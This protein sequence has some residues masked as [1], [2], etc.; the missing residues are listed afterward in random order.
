M[1]LNTYTA[2]G[3]AIATVM[4]VSYSDISAVV[5]DIITVGETRLLREVRTRDMETAL[6][7]LTIA[8]GV[9]TVPSAYLE[10]KHAYID[11]SPTQWL[12]RKPASW[13]YQYYPNR[14]SDG[15]PS[16]IAR[17]G[18]NFIFGPYPDSGYTVKGVYYKSPGS[19]SASAHTF[20]TNNPDLYLFACL[21]E[22]SIFIS[23]QSKIPVWEAKY[24]KILNDVNMQDDKEAYSGSILSV[25]PG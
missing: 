17:E 22:S 10:L 12:E 14:S 24:R 11:K 15:T 1:A 20:F 18:G 5:P 4:D 13:I 16:F 25:V 21:A 19:I 6:G 8:S 9:I 3:S 7:G 23:D 2:L